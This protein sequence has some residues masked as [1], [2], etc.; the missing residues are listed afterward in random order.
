MESPG[1]GTATRIPLAQGQLDIYSAAMG[2][3]VVTVSS[4][5]F[6]LVEWQKQ[7]FDDT[8]SRQTSS[9]HQCFLSV[10]YG[11]NAFLHGLAR[12]EM[13]GMSCGGSQIKDALKIFKVV[14][15]TVIRSAVQIPSS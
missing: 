2:P 11:Y 3:W 1:G 9:S 6:A 10:C 4:R 14:F 5:L 7:S 12:F 15:I 8:K 13:S